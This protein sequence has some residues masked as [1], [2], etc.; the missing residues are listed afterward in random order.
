MVVFQIGH[1]NRTSKTGHQGRTYRR[2]DTRTYRLVL[3]RGRIEDQPV[4]GI[5]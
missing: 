2:Q 4:G 1:Q 5:Q 3:L